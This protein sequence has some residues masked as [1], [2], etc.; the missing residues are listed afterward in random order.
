MSVFKRGKTW[1]YE[2]Q[3]NSARVR[4]SAKSASRTLAR[5]AERSRRRQLEEAANG[6]VRRERP[7]L[8]PIVA[9][10]WARVALRRTQANYARP[11]PHLRWQT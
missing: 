10:R 3:F 4:E 2:F 8:F 5:E 11:L 1:W 9:C 6:I 7:T